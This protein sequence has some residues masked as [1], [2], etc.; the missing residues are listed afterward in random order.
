MQKIMGIK[1]LQLNL[2]RVADAAQ[3][4]E[5]FTIVRDSKPVFTINPVI[6]NMLERTGTLEDLLAAASFKGGP[7]DLSQKIDEIVYGNT[8]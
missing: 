7:K 8:R 4:G 2:K 1:E 3:K 6:E 5:S